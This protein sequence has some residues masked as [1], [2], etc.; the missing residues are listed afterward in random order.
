MAVGGDP[1]TR[2]NV[3]EMTLGTRGCPHDTNLSWLQ[4]LKLGYEVKPVSVYSLAAF[5][6]PVF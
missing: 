4:H 6:N 5:Y 1:L 3:D 2:C